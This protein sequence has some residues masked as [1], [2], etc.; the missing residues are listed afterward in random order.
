MI[1]LAKETVPVSIQTADLEGIA[2]AA[3]QVM[4]AILTS[5]QAAKVRSLTVHHINEC[6]DLDNS[7]CEKVCI[8]T[9]GSYIC[10]CPEGYYGD[11]RKDSKGCIPSNK[12]FPVIKLS[13]EQGEIFFSEKMKTLT[14]PDVF[15]FG[16]LMP[17]EN[18]PLEPVFGFGLLSLL[19]GMTWLYF[20]IKKRKLIKLKEKFFHHNGGFL[21]K[22]QISSNEGGIESTKI[23]TAEELEKATN[24]YADDRILGR[25]G[26]GTVYKGILPDKQVV[27]IKKS[28]IMDESQIERFIN[29]LL[30]GCCLEAEVPL[31]VYEYV[32]NGTLFH[33]IHNTAE[34]A[35]AL[36]YLHS[37]ASKPIIYRDVK[38]ANI[39]L[40]EYYTAK[41]SDFG[42]SRLV[43]AGSNSSHNTGSRDTGI[44]G[45]RILPYK[46]LLTGKKPISTERSQEQKNLATYFI[47]TMKKNRWFQI[48]ELRVVREGTLEQLQ[49]AA[50]LVKRCLHF[51]GEDRPTMKEVAMELEG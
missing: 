31:L 44:F 42:A 9:P 35:G 21:L 2:A 4:R 45:S 24:N 41:I 29:E 18:T 34:A 27:A 7:P 49:A 50:E 22:Q 38:S 51:N 5:A 26:Y 39:L 30:L 46:P 12:E 23:F 36:A 6:A 20:S 13:L 28:R 19:V 11:G 43:P 17:S 1:I 33:H 37:A 3:I 25:G 10:S 14:K 48:L 15:L 40:D 8:N 16:S 47:M 32:S